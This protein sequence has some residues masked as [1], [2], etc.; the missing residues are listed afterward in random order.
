MPRGRHR[1]IFVKYL[2]LEAVG[3]M[4][5]AN[6]PVKCH[7]SPVKTNLLKAAKMNFGITHKR[8]FR[9]QIPAF[10]WFAAILFLPSALKAEHLPIK[11]YTVADGLL[12][13]S[14]S[15]I[16]QDSRGF[17][18]FCTAEGVSRFDGVEMTNFTVADGLPAR[19]VNDFLETGNG[20][21]YIATDKGLA[22]L[23]PNGLRASTENPLFTTVLPDNPKSE[24]KFDFT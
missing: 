3:K 18:W 7:T 17:L 21:I 16:T 2:S 22:R 9:W 6:R 19:Q 13:D 5:I 14:I 20:M 1:R 24:K 15:K 10:V 12:R 4:T 8:C 11:T 23:N